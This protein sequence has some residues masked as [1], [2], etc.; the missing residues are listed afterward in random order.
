MTPSV[1][2]EAQH[3]AG[4]RGAARLF[5]DVSFR[6]DA[7]DVLFVRGPNGSGKTTLLRVLAGL[8]QPS[9]GRVVVDG[10]PMQPFD[11]RWRARVAFVGHAPAVKDELTTE[12]NLAALLALSGE[13][14]SAEA[15]HEGLRAAGLERQRV[16]P[17]RALSQGQRRRIGLARLAAAQRAIWVLDEP[18]TALDAAGVGWL[19]ALV[20]SHAARGGIAVAATHQSLPLQR[21]APASLR[22]G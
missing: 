18:T 6:L 1:H 2:L 9:S 7:G 8:T 22:L 4:T 10:E 15:V 14:A 16:L 21:G 3:L 5:E 19:A 17:A 13:V 11:A 12:E 20:D